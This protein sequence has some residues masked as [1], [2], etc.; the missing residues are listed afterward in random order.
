MS[1]RLDVV[2]GMHVTK[3]EL[4]GL[5]RIAFGTERSMQLSI[6][7]RCEVEDVRG[8]VSLVAFN[9]ANRSFPAGLDALGALYGEAVSA[10]DIG[11]DGAVSLRFANGTELRI[12]VNPDYE[13]GHFVLPDDY[14]VIPP[15]GP[16]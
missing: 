7:S 6:E 1:G 13:A 10:A 16:S 11:P 3:I 15:S 9:P 5:I 8:N 14:V 4:I 2:V 12:P